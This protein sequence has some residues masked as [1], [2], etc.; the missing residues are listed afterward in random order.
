MR[1]FW[2]LLL[3]VVG[4][5]FLGQNFNFWGSQQID[6]ITLFWPLILVLF[7]IAL[8][9]KKSKFNWLIIIVSFIITTLFLYFA[10]LN[11]NSPFK[12]NNEKIFQNSPETYNFSKD[13]S[14]EIK[15]AKV[16]INTG[17]VELNLKENSDFL[18]KG[19]L[20]SSYS[21]PSLNTSFFGET[22]TVNLKNDK[23]KKSVRGKNIFNVELSNKIPIDLIINAGA[24]SINLDLSKINLNDLDL[25]TGASSMNITLGKVTND[26]KL[27]IDT[28]ASSVNI[29]APKSLG[30]RVITKTGLTSKNFN[31]YTKIDNQT[32]ESPDYNLATE[33]I[34]LTI[35]AGASSISI[36]TMQ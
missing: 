8:M 9:T 19:D 15:N 31:G 32:F 21:K 4:L 6:Q 5:I 16:I 36:D 14:N 12:I 13:L 34:T 11:E 2:G 25:N 1:W 3:A 18:I 17:A 22:A 35:S 26:A 30:I 28:G 29:K 24:S 7:G 27:N 20:A 23:F 10:T 33:K